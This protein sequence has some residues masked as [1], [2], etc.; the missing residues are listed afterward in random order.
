MGVDRLTLV[1]DWPTGLRLNPERRLPKDATSSGCWS[2]VV[3][4]GGLKLGPWFL[5]SS[6][7]SLHVTYVML[8]VKR[9][10]HDVWTINIEL[11]GTYQFVVTIALFL[12]CT[13]KFLLHQE[14]KF[15]TADRTAVQIA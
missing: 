11:C 8:Y 13:L 7:L 10:R 4:D 5:G 15:D 9:R 6:P 14:V 3:A 2:V 12:S 1:C